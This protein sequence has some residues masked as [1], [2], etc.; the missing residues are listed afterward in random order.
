MRTLLQDLRYGVRISLKKPGT[1]LVAVLTLAVGVAATTTVFSW[2]DGILLRPIQGVQDPGRL[3]SFENLAPDGRA[4]TTSYQDFREYRDH[5]KLISGLAAT[6]PTAFSLGQGDHPVRVFGELVSGNYFAVLGVKPV[7]GRTFTP[8]EFGDSEGSYPVAVIGQNLW[9]TAFNSDPRVLGRAVEV[10]RQPVT[11]VGVLPPEFH[12][13]FSGLAAQIWLPAMMAVKLSAMPDWMLKDRNSR[14]FVCIAR[15]AP[16][17][18]LAQTRAEAAALADRLAKSYPNP[19]KGLSATLYP[20]WQGHFG[21]QGTML[22]PLEILMAVCA[23][24]LL[25]VCANVANLQLA[26]AM[27]RQQE[28]SV[29]LAIG[30][31]R[32]RLIRQLLTESL[33]LASM[34]SLAGAL[35]ASWTSQAIG[36]LMPPTNMP[37]ALH[38]DVSGDVLLFTVLVGAVVCLASGIAPALHAS[39]V[40]LNQVIKEGAR[41]N[42]GGSGSH[43]VR[44]I[45]VVAEVALALVALIS[46]GL[47][48]RSFEI[49]RRLDPGFDADRVVVSHVQLGTAG[50]PVDKRKL[51]CENLRDR[52]AAMP[53]IE[54][55]AYADFIPQGFD[56]GSWE[57]LQVQGYVPD[58][59]ENMNVYRNVVAP[60]YFRLLR[61]PLLEGR[62]F[63]ALDREKTEQVVIVNQTFARRYFGRGEAIGRKVFGWGRWFT[64]VGVA[65][66]S[67][68]HSPSEKPEPYIYVP[69]RQVY[70]AD[71][72]IA[73]YV[74]AAGN[75]NQAI[76]AMR[77]EV[78]ALDPD[79]DL[80]DAVPLR[81]FIQASLFPQ[82]IGAT[83]L[84]VLGVVALV[85]AAIGLYS[86]LAYSIS[87]RTH[88]IGIRMAL[89]AR[90]ADVRWMMVR[91][92]MAMA[93]VGLF[94]GVA[95]A[96]AITRAAAGV[97]VEISPTDPAVF[98]AATLFLAS[99]AALASY[100][101]AFRATRIDP[102]QALRE[103]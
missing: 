30:A 21:A 77:R 22:A 34:G 73:F 54:A 87:Q 29:R 44:G 59:H 68:Y 58:R 102:N 88:E 46:A 72:D 74:R 57:P 47:F 63:T 69:F 65:R 51:F 13:G 86:V 19:D 70:R 27:G 11:I 50:Y 61:I 78:R 66:D 23:V 18:T 45:L 53:G 32:R 43:R 94:A 25:I 60:G 89:G 90:P 49:A 41:G 8:D 5:L 6:R 9:R 12:G 84:A 67:K 15:L 16:G 7:L 99:V 98:A 33:V 71:L 52:L 95:A 91:Q 62:D 81:D 35:L 97:L 14:M 85:L 48:A 24:V 3:A 26:R 20:M 40:D 42:S 96:L 39:R 1:A 37:V 17:V 80:Y 101:P 93:G 103:R 82:K 36:Y 83:L 31:G 2:I 55:A 75:P 100:V 56:Y 38:I 92:G 10:N 64:V 79:L 76:A 4:M 28:F